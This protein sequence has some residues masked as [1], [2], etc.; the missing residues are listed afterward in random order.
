MIILYKYGL[1]CLWENQEW[2]DGAKDGGHFNVST[3]YDGGKGE[4]GEYEERELS[5]KWSNSF[6]KDYLQTMSRFSRYLCLKKRQEEIKT[7]RIRQKK[8]L[9][10]SPKCMNC[11]Q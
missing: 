1:G 10:A 6:N 2:H 8:R 5:D 3:M 7:W 11:V 9:K 4:E